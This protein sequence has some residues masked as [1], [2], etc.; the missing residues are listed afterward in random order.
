MTQNISIV[1]ALLAAFWIATGAAA[2]SYPTKGI[3]IVVPYPA[4]SSPDVIARAIGQKLNEAWRQPVVIENKPG[5]GDI[6]GTEAVA[7]SAPDGYTVLLHS[8]TH[9]I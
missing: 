9:A 3:T 5:A 8:A 1:V 2:Q 7:K 6:V 4:G